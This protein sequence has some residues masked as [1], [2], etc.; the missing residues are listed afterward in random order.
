MCYH[1]RWIVSVVKI[2]WLAR[3]HPT[4]KRVNFTNLGPLRYT[5]GL[6]RKELWDEKMADQ[7]TPV[8]GDTHVITI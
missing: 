5:H 2:D 8:G 7:P 3:Q 4:S 1:I 6:Q